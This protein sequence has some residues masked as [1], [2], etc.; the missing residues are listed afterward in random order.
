MGAAVFRLRGHYDC[1]GSLICKIFGWSRSL[2]AIRAQKLAEITLASIGAVLVLIAL[3]ANQHW[4]DRHFLPSFLVPRR[5]Y[6]ALET[7]ARLMVG[8]VGVLS[9]IVARRRLARFAASNATRA[10]P[11]A[12]AAIA[13]FVAADLVLDHVRASDARWQHEEP[14]RRLDPRLGWTVVPSRAIQTTVGGRIIDYAFDDFGYRVR[15]VDEPVDPERPTI[16]FTGES[17]IF[18]EGLTWEESIP[19]RV[20]AMTGLQSANLAVRGYANDQAYLRLETELPRFPR[21]VAVVSLFMTTLFGRNLESE[22]PHLGPGLVWLPP[23]RRS[24]LESLA[25]LLIFY[26]SEPVIARGV[27]VTREVLDATADL[28]RARGAEPLLVVPQFGPEDATEQRL[29][30]RVLDG[31]RLPS[32]FVEIDPSWHLPWN[33]HPNA[34]AA[35]VIAA[36]IADRLGARTHTP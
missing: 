12:I 8:T 4:L 15:R 16:V 25:R 36:A 9:A 28:A 17:V 13:A 31:L 11:I 30:H 14:L 18:G 26:H 22:R 27:A 32:V 19:A 35:R 2:T 33:Q 7:F 29:R 21:P 24:S 20:A 1:D 5:W 3:G 23:V 6:V 34:A 10:L